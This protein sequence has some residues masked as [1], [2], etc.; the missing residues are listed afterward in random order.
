MGGP[1]GPMLFA[2]IA[3][4]GPRASG[5]K[6]PPTVALLAG[7]PRLWIPAFAGMTFW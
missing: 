6:L 4:L 2:Q 3:A 1:S 5:L 7:A